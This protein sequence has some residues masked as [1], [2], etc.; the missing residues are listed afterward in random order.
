M[1]LSDGKL[2]CPEAEMSS[3]L[4]YVALF[5]TTTSQIIL[6]VAFVII[7]ALYLGRRRNR[8]AKARTAGTRM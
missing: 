2:G 7:L 8:K 6:W 3:L 5:A 1:H 4:A